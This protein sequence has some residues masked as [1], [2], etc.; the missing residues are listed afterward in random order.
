MV[1]V[2]V[3]MGFARV[4]HGFGKN[5]VFENLRVFTVYGRVLDG[6]LRVVNGF[7]M[8]VYGV[9]T[10]FERVP[11]FFPAKI[12]KISKKTIQFEESAFVSRLLQ[13]ESDTINFHYCN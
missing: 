10:G 1:F 9:R 5:L 13:G 7:Q 12:L 2:R 11:G 8:G 4:T 3:F 6:F